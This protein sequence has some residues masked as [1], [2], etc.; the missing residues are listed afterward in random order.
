MNAFTD[1]KEDVTIDAEKNK[2]DLLD[3]LRSILQGPVH[4]IACAGQQVFLQK[5]ERK[6]AEPFRPAGV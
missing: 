2:A 4:L 3:V 1:K 6:A 5:G